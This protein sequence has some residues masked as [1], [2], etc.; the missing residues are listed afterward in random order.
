MREYYR[1]DGGDILDADDFFDTG[2]VATI[3]PQGF[4]HITDRAKD[5]IKSG[6]EWISSI[7]IE[8]IA[9]GH[10]KALIAA[11]IGVPHPKWE[12]RP[13]LLVQLKPGEAATAEEFIAFLDGKIAKWWIPGRGALRRG[14]SARRDRQ[15][16]QEADP[17]TDGGIGYLGIGD[18][19]PPFVHGG[20]VTEGDKGGVSG[21]RA[22]LEKSPLRSLTRVASPVKNGGREGNGHQVEVEYATKNRQDGA[23][24]PPNHVSTR[25][26]VMGYAPAPGSGGIEVSATAFCRAVRSRFLLRRGAAGG[27]GRRNGP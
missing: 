1:G 21:K 24:A 14:D 11:V 15:D 19:L 23:K 20:N 5:V 7:E 25:D 8:N 13:L 9:A 12:E 18:S 6:G 16:R 2:D 3:D 26:A 27:R 10:P 22:P 17:P 4:M